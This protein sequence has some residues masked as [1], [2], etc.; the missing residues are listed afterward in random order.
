MT[1]DIIVEAA[2]RVLR[3]G[4]YAGL[5]TRRVAEVAGASVGSLYQYFPNRR[6]IAAE[7]VR[8]RA[9]GVLRV[10]EATD[11]SGA[12]TLGDAV[13]I[14]MESL[15][16]EKRP[17]LWLSV[18]L[19][20]AM[21]EIEG[22][23]LVIER[24]RQSLPVLAAKLAPCVGGTTPDARRLAVAAAAVEGAIWEAIAGDPAIVAAPTFKHTLTRI[25]MA[26]LVA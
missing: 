18:A 19:A 9:D 4:G 12:A 2:V 24:A 6:A 1:V 23:R 17:W 21:P 3:N 7:L 13:A 15:L 26:A 20:D 11:V 5:T 16:E 14:L 8:R 22:R 25:F 10:L